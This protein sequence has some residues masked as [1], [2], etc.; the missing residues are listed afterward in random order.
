MDKRI[1][2]FSQVASINRFVLSGGKEDGLKI[3]EVDTGRIRFWLNESKALDI[4]RFWHDGK[5]IGFLSKNGLTK[6]EVPFQK[7]FEGGMLYTCGLDFVGGKE[8]FETHGTIHNIPAKVVKC[9]IDEEKII[10]EGIVED[11]ELFGKNLVL[12][13]RITCDV[14]GEKVNVEDVLKNKGTADENYCLLYHINVGY[15]MLDENVRI[16]TDAISVLPRT[17]YAKERIDERS[18]FLAPKDNE[19]ECCYFLDMKTPKVVVKNDKL[20]ETLEMTYSK[21]SLPCFVQWNSNASFDYALGIEPSTTNL[22]E[23]FCYKTLCTNNS[24][25]FFVS[26][27]VKNNK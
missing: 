24:E 20:G 5:N 14:L 25:R 15:P 1:S 26:I 16:E 17:E 6:R 4:S 10:V 8:G 13:R 27:E 18:V 7:R 19:E 23:Y 9:E 2:N 22:D 11:T 21:D 3:I 12:K